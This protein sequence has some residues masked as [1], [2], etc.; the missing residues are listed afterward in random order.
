[1]SGESIFVIE[2]E[3]FIALQIKELLEKHGYRVT[4][5]MAY[6]EEAIAMAEKNPP[7]L[8]CMDIGLMGKLDGIETAKKI[9]Q[10]HDIPIIFLTAVSDNSH[11]ARVKETISYNF[12]IKP[13]NERELLA[14]VEMTL[15][16][17]RIDQELRESMERY[18]AIVDNAAES[19]LLISCGT[20][21]ILEANP[22]TVRLLGYTSEELNHMVLRDIL[23]LPAGK[24]MG[25]EEIA[26]TPEGWSG[27]VRFQCRDRSYREAELYSRIIHRK[28]VPDAAC[29]VVHDITD[30]KQ[31][32]TAL[33]EA[34]RKLNLLTSVTRHDILNQLTVLS[35]FL[36]LSVPEVTGTRLEEYVDRELDAV[37][38]IQRLIRFTK[39]YEE[40]GQSKPGWNRP[41]GLILELKRAE[42]SSGLRIDSQLGALEIFADPLF[43]RVL[44][45]LLDNTLRHGEHVKKITVTAE[46]A[47][48]GLVIRWA[49]DGVGIADA[50][51]EK[52]FERGFGKNTGLGLFLARE[53]LGLTGIT[54]RET[55][56]YGKGAEFE[57][58]VPAGAFR[59][60]G[61]P[62]SQ[63]PRDPVYRESFPAKSL[64][65]MSST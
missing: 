57:L 52:I 17:H 4:G 46:P 39:E 36:E 32:E 63:P 16:H 37:G 48:N 1:M 27:E 11:L 64:S 40:I 6:G 2:D 8:I 22:A 14:S 31:I 5:V 13:Y 15:H 26:C 19:I 51:K 53:I 20:G 49:D 38:I 23:E 56:I 3:G 28:G 7:D 65:S 35:G 60:G 33:R 12:I 10:H 30:R 29:M 62:D 59:Y 24:T 61:Q 42:R 55:G 50:D 41:E 54:I 47:G 58:T 44:H 21:G 25:W 34:N 45:N 9:Q 43:E 18:R